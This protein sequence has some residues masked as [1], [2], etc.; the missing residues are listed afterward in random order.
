MHGADRQQA[1]LGAAGGQQI[2]F[3]VAALEAHLDDADAFVGQ[4]FPD[5]PVGGEFFV[6]DN[7]LVAGLPVD[8]EGN[9]RQRLGS[10]LDQCDVIRRRCI[11][12]AHQ[13]FT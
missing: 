8:T 5:N 6:A 4:G 1:N 10:V 3:R 13:A 7:D 12:Q 2:A 11:R 9:E